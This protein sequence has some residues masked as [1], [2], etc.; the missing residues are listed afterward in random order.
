MKLCKQKKIIGLILSC[1]LVGL[2]SS[3]GST[4]DVVSKGFIQK[5]KYK[6]GWFINTQSIK[7]IKRVD[8]SE[9]RTKNSAF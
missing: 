9:S 6:K 5:R 3:C 8:L 1:L 2:L 4:N 7:P